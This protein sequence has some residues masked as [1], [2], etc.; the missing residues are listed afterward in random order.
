M[1]VLMLRPSY[2]PE[3]SGGTH[4]AVDLVEDMIANDIE[5]ILVVPAP[6]RV[7]DKVKEEV[8]ESKNSKRNL[9]GKLLF[10]VLMF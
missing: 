3:I 10:I 6:F 7:D 4:L 5:V 9:I 1:K 2:V 8:P